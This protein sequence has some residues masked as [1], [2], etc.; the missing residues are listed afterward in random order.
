MPPQRFALAISLSF[1]IA[2]G[3]CRVERTP[4]EYFDNASSVEADRQAAEA[5]I[6]DRL[7]AFVGAAARGSA[8]EALVALNPAT[9][10]QLIAPAQIEVEGGESLR[11]MM[12]TLLPTA[13]ALELHELEVETGAAA[14]V[15]WFRMVVE[16]PGMTPEPSLY[17]ASGL[18][19]RDAGLWQ[20]VQAHVSG[21]LRP[22]SASSPPDSAA[23]AEADG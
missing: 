23:I 5:E 13:V 20:L 22:D 21:P 19:L 15:A 6:R 11:Q 18:F 10:A 12:T 1:L 16:G 14:R 8:T 7:S 17:R 9:D 3:G 2:L 4:D